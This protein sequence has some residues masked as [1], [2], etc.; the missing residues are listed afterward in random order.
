MPRR[1]FLLPSCCSPRECFPLLARNGKQV[2]RAVLRVDALQAHIK[3]RKRRLVCDCAN[4]AARQ[5]AVQ[6]DQALV[7]QSAGRA[8]NQQKVQRNALALFGDFLDFDAGR[9]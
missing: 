7:Q 5:S 1:A 2:G 3:I 6:A 9:G 8:I 4:E